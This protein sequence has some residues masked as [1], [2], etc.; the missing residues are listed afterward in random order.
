MA[1]TR[2]AVRTWRNGALTAIESRRFALFWTAL[3]S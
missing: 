1:G 3:R 2:K